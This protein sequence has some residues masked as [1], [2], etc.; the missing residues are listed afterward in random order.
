M[1]KVEHNFTHQQLVDIAA[2]WLGNTVGCDA[3]LAELVLNSYSTSREIPDAV[4]WKFGSSSILIECK[5]SRSD[6]HADREKTF[7]KV[8]KLGIGRHRYYMAP[9]GILN[10]ADMQVFDDHKG[11]VPTGWGL[12]EVD[13][14]HRV[15]KVVEC[16]HFFQ[17]NEKHEIAMLVGAL[18]RV[19]I[20]LDAPL[21]K[22]IGPVSATK[23]PMIHVEDHYLESINGFQY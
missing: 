12:L 10:A 14:A 9:R 11:F 22:F 23:R 15:H 6:F 8:Q 20:R 1:A 4:G 2:R 7:R 5:T 3:V 19:Q 13:K 16:D 21:H 18:R 17:R